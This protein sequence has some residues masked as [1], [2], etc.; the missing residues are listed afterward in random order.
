MRFFFLFLVFSIQVAA[1][2]T[3]FTKTQEPLLVRV[4]EISKIEVSYKN[5]YNP[6]G[7]I[8]KIGNSQILKIVYENGKEESRFQLAQKTDANP[9]V[10]LNNQQ[11]VI[12]GH[13]ISINN[14]DISCKETF[15][16]MLKRD[17]HLNSDELNNCLLNAESKKN[18]QL[19]FIIVSP[20]CF[21]G[22]VYFGYKHAKNYYYGKQSIT[23][24]KEIFLT[25]AALAVIT[26]TTA[27]I[28]KSL[29]NKQIRKAAF[30]YNQE[31]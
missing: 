31:L 21:V 8:Y 6:D 14:K 20:L 28:Y 7:V 13:H 27:L 11:F 17:A 12:E 2:D 19:G 26:A 10:T 5:F 29:K 9:I 25:G 23:E 4:L 18:G 16:I 15:K 1:Q 3:I 24:G 22:G 30:L